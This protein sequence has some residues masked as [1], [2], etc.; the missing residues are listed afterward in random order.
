[1][2]KFTLAIL[3]VF[4]KFAFV[5]ISSFPLPFFEPLL[6]LAVVYTF[7]HSLDIKSWAFY[8][9]FC[10][11]LREIFSLDA[12]GIYIVSFLITC[13][14]VSVLARLLYRDNWVF[15]FPVVFAGVFLCDHVVLFLKS[16]FM[17]ETVWILN[18]GW[19]FVRVLLKSIA[20]AIIV[21]PVF[22]FS[23]KCVPEL[24]A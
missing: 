14:A 24:I 11:V 15:V 22:Y 9:I 21:Y 1:M 10:A 6:A 20:T 12:F 5:Q 19:V 16:F 3:L 17:E 4:A 2:N 8:C 7:F 18:Y 23:K 13:V